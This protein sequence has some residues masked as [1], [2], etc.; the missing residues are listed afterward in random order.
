MLASAVTKYRIKQAKDFMATAILNQPSIK[1]KIKMIRNKQKIE[2]S[3]P[4]RQSVDVSHSKLIK[5]YLG[6]W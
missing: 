3:Q 4:A 2:A 1:N 6:D 5:L